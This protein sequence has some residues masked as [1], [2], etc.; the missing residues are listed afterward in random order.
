MYQQFRARGEFFV[1]PSHEDI[2]VRVHDDDI[3]LLKSFKTL[4]NYIKV[5]NY[6]DV[7]SL[8]GFTLQNTL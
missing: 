2:D 6:T 7:S 5:D 1:R 8:E 4:S 3:T